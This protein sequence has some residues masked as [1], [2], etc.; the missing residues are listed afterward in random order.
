MKSDLHTPHVTRQRND[1]QRH[2][3]RPFPEAID[4]RVTVELHPARARDS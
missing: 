2:T 1:R 4:S 3:G